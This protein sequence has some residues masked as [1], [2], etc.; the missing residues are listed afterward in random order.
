MFHFIHT[1][2]QDGKTLL[3]AHFPNVVFKSHHYETFHRLGRNQILK[4]MY[5]NLSVC[6][7][8]RGGYCSTFIFLS[9]CT[10]LIFFVNVILI[11][12]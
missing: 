5:V 1:E 6:C 12:P 11:L 4:K 2:I 8:G 7:L 9:I 10:K 3:D